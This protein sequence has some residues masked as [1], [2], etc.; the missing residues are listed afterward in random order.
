MLGAIAGDVIGSVYE[1]SPVKTANDQEVSDNRTVCP[2]AIVSLFVYA[3]L[4]VLVPGQTPR[5][6]GADPSDS[7]M[8]IRQSIN[9]RYHS[10]RNGGFKEGLHVEPSL[11]ILVHPTV[12]DRKRPVQLVSPGFEQ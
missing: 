1:A 6:S 9:G 10:L 4:V 12:R 8:I 11:R 3:P 5:G 2:G 7:F